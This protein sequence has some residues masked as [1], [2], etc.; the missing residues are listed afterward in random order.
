MAPLPKPPGERV[1][2]NLDQRQ[3]RQI[4]RGAVEVPPM[5]GAASLTR[6][7][8]EV[9]EEYWRAL[10]TELGAL[11]SDADRFPLARLCRLHARAMASKR[12]LSAQAEGELRQL[13]AAFG[14][15]PL[16]RLR[17]MVEVVDA[18]GAP[19]ADSATPSGVVVDM[20]AQRARRARIERAT[21]TTRGR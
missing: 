7:Q 21:E 1:R 9:A 16:G 5:P 6:R 20:R 12:G 2:R 17:L 13:E 11:F 8:R 19:G 14:V 4:Q 18:E 15:S 10:W 3:W